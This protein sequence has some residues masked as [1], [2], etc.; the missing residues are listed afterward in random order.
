MRREAVTE[1]ATDMFKATFC[2]DPDIRSY[3]A[4]IP[5]QFIKLMDQNLINSGIKCTKAAIKDQQTVVKT[6]IGSENKK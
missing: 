4:D 5:D 2:N 6:L 1:L 3:L